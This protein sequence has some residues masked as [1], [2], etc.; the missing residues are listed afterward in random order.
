MGTWQVSEI[1]DTSC[2]LANMVH[3]FEHRFD[4]V[5]TWSC[6]IPS[7]QRYDGFCMAWEPNLESPVKLGVVQFLL[8]KDLHP[9]AQTEI[10]LEYIMNIHESWSSWCLFLVG[11]T[12][13]CKNFRPFV[14]GHS[15]PVTAFAECADGRLAGTQDLTESWHLF[16]FP[17][18]RFLLNCIQ[19]YLQVVPTIFS[20]Q[21]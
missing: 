16:V 12:G 8:Q 19:E 21:L 10:Y 14:P 4:E 20:Q 13:S 17:A 2:L 18:L 3:R 7:T 5:M 9:K 15:Q 6:W 1:S 11:N